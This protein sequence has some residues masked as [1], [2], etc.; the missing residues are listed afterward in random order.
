MSENASLIRVWLFRVLVAT[1]CGLMIWGF[2]QPFWA[3]LVESPGITGSVVIY[4]WG[5][6]ETAGS[7]GYQIADDITP[8]YQIRLAWAFMGIICLLALL[9]TFLKG[10]KG[11]LL[12]GA[13][14]I[15]T[16]AYALVAIFVVIKERLTE[17]GIALQGETFLGGGLRL[18]IQS[19]IEQGF[20]I[21]VICASALIILAALRFLIAGKA[22]SK[23]S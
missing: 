23:G 12:L 4:G 21:M 1:A 20:Y 15:G 11:Q 6:P 8:L 16:L 3:G 10:L 5:I 7:I 14:G 9:S 13:V 22:L 18:T 19:D 2:T 17:M